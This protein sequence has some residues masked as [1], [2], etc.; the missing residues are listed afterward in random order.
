[1]VRLSFPTEYMRHLAK[2]NLFR[3]NEC[4]YAFIL[5]FM[6][7]NKNTMSVLFESII[8]YKH[9]RIFWSIFSMQ[10]RSVINGRVPPNYWKT[11]T[12]DR[13]QRKRITFLS[14]FTVWSVFYLW[15]LQKTKF[16]IPQCTCP[17]SHDAP[18]WNRN[19]QM[20]AHG[21][22]WDFCPLRC[23]VCEMGLYSVALYPTTENTWCILILDRI[24]HLHYMFYYI[25]ICIWVTNWLAWR[26][27]DMAILSALLD[28]CEEIPL[29]FSGSLSQRC[30]ALTISF[31]LTWTSCCPHALV[32]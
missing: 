25:L 10:C 3:A 9:I 16:T 6:Y 18:F 30:W 23:G 32:I 5:L 1:M 12:R 14:E 13:P 7:H 11:A 21:V 29:V 24:Y 19:V 4:Y 8:I 26:H 28:L 15:C 17:I 31:I 2:K 27:H 20:C 22:L